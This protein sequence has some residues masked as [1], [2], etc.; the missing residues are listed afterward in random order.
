MM[1]WVTAFIFMMLLSLWLAQPQCGAGYYPAVSLSK[2]GP[3]VCVQ[4]YMPPGQS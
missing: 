4:G 2:E 1:D 3:W